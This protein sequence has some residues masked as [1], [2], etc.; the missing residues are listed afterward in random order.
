M[1]FTYPSILERASEDEV[2]VAFRD[3][4]ECH[5]SGCDEADALAEAQD[6]LAEAIAGRIDDNEPIP[7]PSARRNGELLVPVP[8]EVASKAALAI[9]YHRSELTRDALAR[10]L[11]VDRETVRDMLDPRYATETASINR[12]L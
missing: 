8:T 2:V 3:L 7:K 10:V 5:T 9:A 6:A 11:N 1:R 12:A 4:P